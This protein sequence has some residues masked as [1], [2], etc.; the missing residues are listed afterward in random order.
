MAEQKSTGMAFTRGIRLEIV[1]HS[2]AVLCAIIVFPEGW[3]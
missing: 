3:T 1:M 2:P